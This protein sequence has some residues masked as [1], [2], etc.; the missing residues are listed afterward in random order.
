MYPFQNQFYPTM[1]P[2][3]PVQPIQLTKQEAIKVNGRAGADAY[4]LAPNSSVLM[5]DNTAP[6]V[7]LAVSDGA[8]YKTLT[9]YD[10]KVHEEKK[11]EDNYKKLEERIRKLEERLNNAN[12]KSNNS[13]DAKQQRKPAE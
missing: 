3:A 4:Q 9:A 13:A 11:P 7:W 1:Q 6:I 5:L 12:G 8:G 10:I 2:V